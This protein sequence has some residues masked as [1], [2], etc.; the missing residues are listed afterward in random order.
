MNMM[1]GFGAILS[2]V[3]TPVLFDELP[4]EMSKAMR[5]Q[6]IFSLFAAAWVLAALAW[7][8]IDASKPLFRDSED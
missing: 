6:I 4:E 8:W 5:W 1:G 7:L 3:L 2:P